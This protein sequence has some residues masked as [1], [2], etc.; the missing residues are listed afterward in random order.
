MPGI[1][2]FVVVYGYG[3]GE[4]SRG[5]KLGANWRPRLQS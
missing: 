3:I 4:E 5:G 2:L 1:C